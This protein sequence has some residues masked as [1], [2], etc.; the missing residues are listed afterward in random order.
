M[1]ESGEGGEKEEGENRT[2]EKSLERQCLSGLK[3]AVLMCRGEGVPHLGNYPPTG[4]NS[5]PA[6]GCHRLW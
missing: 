6:P 3:Q 1:E 5:C 2:E 4:T